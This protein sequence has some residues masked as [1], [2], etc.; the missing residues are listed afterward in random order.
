M[1]IYYHSLET[2]TRPTTGGR[3]MKDF[4]I[5]WLSLL[6]YLTLYLL[7]FSALIVLFG[8]LV[9]VNKTLAVVVMLLL[10]S[11]CITIDG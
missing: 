1:S 7:I 4:I 9:T 8:Y 2:I 3:G 10:A 11:L 6:F 5:E